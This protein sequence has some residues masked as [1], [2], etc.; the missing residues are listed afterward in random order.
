[1]VVG[2]PEMPKVSLKLGSEPVKLPPLQ[3]AERE[4]IEIAKLFD[5]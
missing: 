3:F 1:M 2:N 4:A 5:I